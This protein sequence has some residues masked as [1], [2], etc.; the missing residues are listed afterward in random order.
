MGRLLLVLILLLV[1]G[2]PLNLAAAAAAGLDAIAARGLPAILVL[3]VRIACTAFGVAAGI[4]LWRRQQAA[5]TL[6]KLSLTASAATETFVLLTHYLPSNRAPG[7]EIF[8]VG[9]TLAYYLFWM[10]YLSRWGNKGIGE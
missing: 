2:Q 1:A 10:T 3:L 4:A 9:A 8:Y 7:D 6:A 5:I